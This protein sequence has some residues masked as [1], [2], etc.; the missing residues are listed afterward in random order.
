M[1][2]SLKEDQELDPEAKDTATNNDKQDEKPD[3]TKDMSP[4]ERAKDA[5][6][7]VM[8]YSK[9]IQLVGTRLTTIETKMGIIGAEEKKVDEAESTSKRTQAIPELRRVSWAGFKN[10]IKD[11]KKIYAVEAL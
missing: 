9:Y 2:T 3:D 11:N 5:A 1:P 4:E 10:Q 7:K 6:N 8:E